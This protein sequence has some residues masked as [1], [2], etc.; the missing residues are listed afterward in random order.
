MIGGRGDA[1]S[2]LKALPN[3]ALVERV[4]QGPISVYKAYGY[5]P[6]VASGI[7]FQEIYEDL[8]MNPEYFLMKASDEKMKSMHNAKIEKWIADALGVSKKF[9]DGDYGNFKRKK[10][11]KLGNFLKGQM[12]NENPGL[13]ITV[14][15]EYDEG[16]KK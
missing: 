2:T 4:L 7:S 5:P 13:I 3:Y 12:E 11:K 16:V 6:G 15:R 10:D 14:V 9:A 8:R 1:G